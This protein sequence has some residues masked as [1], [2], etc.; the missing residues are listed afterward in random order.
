M[1]KADA[2][3]QRD[4]RSI[5]TMR[6][7]CVC[8]AIEVMAA[9]GGSAKSQQP[10]N[11]AHAKRLTLNYATKLGDPGKPH[12]VGGTDDHVLTHLNPCMRRQRAIVEGN[13]ETKSARNP[14]TPQHCMRR[15]GR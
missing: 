7:E 9:D 15:K 12:S 13:A 2:V 14:A 4:G 10:G 6:S 11:T 5:W 3:G 8:H 1:D